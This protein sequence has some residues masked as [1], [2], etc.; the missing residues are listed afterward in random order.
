MN[1][2]FDV[3][4]VLVET[5]GNLPAGA[6]TEARER[7]AALARFTSRPILAARVRLVYSLKPAPEDRCAARAML[8][9][10]GH[11]LHA[12]AV[13]ATMQGAIAEIQDRLRVELGRL[14]KRTH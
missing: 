14:R 8:D 2:T 7:L 6:V 5:G 13:A 10:N 4:A 9:V 3:D 1:T 12:H 11:P